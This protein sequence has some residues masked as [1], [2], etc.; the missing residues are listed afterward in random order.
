[1]QHAPSAQGS[2]PVEVSAA[3]QLLRR[4]WLAQHVLSAPGLPP[5]GAHPAQL[6]QVPWQAP[7]A[8]KWLPVGVPAEERR[9]RLVAMAQ[10]APLAPGLQPIGVRPAPL[11]RARQVVLVAS[12]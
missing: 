1:M 7:F 2:T 11:R 3:D 4:R 10:N 12:G 8:M 6:L 5:A 9:Q